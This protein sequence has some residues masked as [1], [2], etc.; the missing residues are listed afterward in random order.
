MA[1]ADTHAPYDWAAG[2]YEVRVD[3]AACSDSDDATSSFPTSWGQGQ[4]IVLRTDCAA[5]SAALVSGQQYHVTLTVLGTV[6]D[7]GMVQVR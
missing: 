1:L 4:T 2:A 7:L 5:T 6:S 3:G